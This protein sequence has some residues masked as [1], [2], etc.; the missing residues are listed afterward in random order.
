MK[1]ISTVPRA[2]A[3]VDVATGEAGQGAPP[4]L[5]R[6]RGARRRRRRRGHGRAGARRRGR[7]RS[8]AATRSTEIRRN[9]EAYLARSRT[10]SRDAPI[11][12]RP[13]RRARRPAGR[14][15][16]PPSAALLAERL[17]AG[18]TATPT[19]TSRRAA[20]KPI[21]E[22]FVED[23]EPHFRALE[24]DAVRA[25]LAEH[26]GVLA[27]GGGAVLDRAPG[28]CSPGG[29]VV[30]F[31]DVGSPTPRR[32]SASTASRPLLPATRGAQWRS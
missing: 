6:L 10:C 16:S 12:R 28:R 15:A 3:T 27:L 31:L 5:R 19:P 11:R 8:S 32:G 13:A 17:A 26:D 20:G 21:A 30:V 29:A 2:L 18:R 25:A 9:L 7:W 23:G 4:A 24:R 14:R 1:P 22:I